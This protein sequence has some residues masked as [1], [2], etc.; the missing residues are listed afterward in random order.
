MVLEQR[1]A[2]VCRPGVHAS[3][4]VADGEDG[5]V[6]RDRAWWAVRRLQKLL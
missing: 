2:P 1:N 4:L 5:G 3:A 6:A